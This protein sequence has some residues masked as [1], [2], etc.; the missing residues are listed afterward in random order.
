MATN[1]E[2][3]TGDTKKKG[4]EVNAKISKLE[5]EE[6]VCKTKIGGLEEKLGPLE[7]AV[8][9]ATGELDKLNEEENPSERKI[10]NAENKLARAEKTVDD[11][12][13]NLDAANANLL[14]I[15][16]EKLALLQQSNHQEGKEC[17]WNL[18]VNH[19]MIHIMSKFVCLRYWFNNVLL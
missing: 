6:D 15:R 4:N 7:E 17:Q 2:N 8:R 12:Q 9:V 13:K 11:V 1:A 10:K 19:N 5:D 16:Q 18:V 14:S 3:D